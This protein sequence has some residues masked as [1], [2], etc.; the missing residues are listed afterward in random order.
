MAFARIPPV[1]ALLLSALAPAQDAPRL[2]LHFD[3]PKFEKAAT[4]VIQRIWAT[5][6]DALPIDTEPG[7]IHVY[8]DVVRNQAIAEKHGQKATQSLPGFID[9]K[10]NAAHVLFWRDGFCR[11][12]AWRIGTLTMQLALGNASPLDASDA[13]AWFEHGIAAWAEGNGVGEK[14]WIEARAHVTRGLSS[15][16]AV[17]S[18]GTRLPGLRD[19]LME[20]T[21]AL[22]R[23]EAVAAHR[24]AF[25]FLMTT[26][27]DATCAA[28]KVAVSLATR[29][30]VRVAFRDGLRRHLGNEAFD[31]LDERFRK[32]VEA[33]PKSTDRE[34][35]PALDGH[36]QRGDA[37]FV[38]PSPAILWLDDNRRTKFVVTARPQ[39]VQIGQGDFVFERSKGRWIRVTILC[40]KDEGSVHVTERIMTDGAPTGWRVL[41]AT[42]DDV[43]GV[44]LGRSVAIE[45]RLVRRKLDIRVEGQHVL[46]VELPKGSM[47]GRYGVGGPFGNQVAWRRVRVRKG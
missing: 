25:H 42:R 27:R 19:I 21:E 2:R 5:A 32:H 20:R 8:N 40:Q 43:K 13:P 9:P 10:R 7:T 45:M 29:A 44:R 6:T 38:P 41:G 11:D 30:E 17:R 1:T 22:S 39:L 37:D 26:H 16:S 33:L 47:A 23:D 31:S 14:G 46:T 36:G 4:A 34:V 15:T 12:A 18:A 28:L 3:D 24:I 35:Y